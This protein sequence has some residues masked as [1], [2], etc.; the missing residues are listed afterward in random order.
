M[1]RTFRTNLCCLFMA[2]V[3][4]A[5]IRVD[6][7]APP[8]TEGPRALAIEMGTPFHDNAILQ[9]GMKVPVWGWSKPGATV[10]VTFAGQK[11]TAKV[12]T[13]GKWMLELDSLKASFEPAEMVISGGGK[14]ETLTNILVG[15]VW[16]AS[17]Q[18]NMQWIAGKCDVGRYLISEMKAR[19]E[20]GEEKLAVI[21]EAKVT[22]VYAVLQPIQR[23]KGQWNLDEANFS[24]ISYAFAHTL[25][26]ELQVPIGILNCSFS[27]TA[28]QAWVPKEGFASGEDEYT[29]AIYQRVLKAD[30]T[31]PEHKKAWAGYYAAV[32]KLMKENE[33]RL[34]NGQLPLAATSLDVPGVFKGNR[35]ATWLFNARTSP[36]IPYAIRGAI[37]NQGY[38]NSGEGLV[39]YNNLHSMIRGWRT[40]WDRPDL[41]VY[42]HQF[43]SNYMKKDVVNTPSVSTTSEMRL[44]TTMARDIPN[45]G[46]ASQI[47]ITG[48]IH[49][50][51]KTVP[52]QRLALHALKNQYGKKIVADGPIFKSYKAQGNKLIVNFDHAE[53]GLVVAEPRNDTGKEEN[54]KAVLTYYAPRV[55][56]NADDKVSLFYLV[57][58][59]RV[60]HPASVTIKGETVEL[61]S[62]AVKKPL[63]VSY[64]TAG[65]GFQPN[66][67]NN[68]LLPMSPFIYFDH[69]MVTKAE[70]P[71]DPMKIVGVELDASAG[72]LMYDY[73]KMPILGPQFRDN[74]VL[75]AG[76]PITIWGSAVHDHGTDADGKGV[77][78][79]SFNGI[80]KTIPVADD[81]P[82]VVQLAPGETR[83]SGWKEWRVTVPAMAAS[84][85]PKTLKV[86]FT[87][88]GQLAHERIATNIVVGDVWYVAASSMKVSAPQVKSSG[89]IVRVMTRKAKGSVSASPRRYSVCVSRT[90]LNRFASFWADSSGDK[91][92]GLAAILGHRIAAKTGNPVGIIYMQG[93]ALPL[94]SWM[95]HR[96][97]AKA[98]SLAGPYASITARFPGSESYNSNIKRYVE[99]W[100]TYWSDYIP[101]MMAEKRVP[102][103]RAW[104]TYPTTAS[105]DTKTDASQTYNVLMH[106]FTP[107][108]LK[109]VIF[110]TTPESFADNEGKLFD[111]QMTALANGWKTRFGGDPNFMYTVPSKALAPK[112]TNPSKIRGKST[113]IEVSSWTE[114]H[115]VVEAAVGK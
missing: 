61:T 111:E 74:A 4:L 10:T 78:H 3:L 1:K 96:S 34:K 69:K 113:A 93:G 83:S 109:G 24:A 15:E 22:D 55:M 9:R 46:M 82:D 73:R 59:D 80:E 47:D 64:A 77:I 100:E 115:K 72:G 89:K 29:K 13:N 102:D 8:K 88:D 45:A 60:W 56:E 94:R 79:F 23:A 39:Y 17:G 66:L 57:G 105:D 76:V 97:L 53:G 6:A 31:T 40:V 103:A 58:K 28:I 114:G 21:R 44:G 26:Q 90:P 71:D 37:W 112:I 95:D 25:F 108:A 110:L 85:E 12:A 36:M 7:A 50:Q 33:V 107:A 87:V 30:P 42:F 35:D 92:S 101:T 11:K 106:S 104:G 51:S 20:A 65:V 62:S 27:Q 70:W 32:E 16:M 52:G 49:Y 38:A 19:V 18:S 54:G 2:V 14:T 5:S 48:A 81:N 91:A 67:Y 68:A 98:P 63:G 75:Q 84:A 99:A 43:Y 86:S 41:P